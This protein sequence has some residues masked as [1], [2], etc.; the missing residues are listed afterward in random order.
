MGLKLPE[1]DIPPST[2]AARAARRE[3]RARDS[4]SRAPLAQPANRPDVIVPN[5]GW[6]GSFNSPTKTIVRLEEPPAHSNLARCARTKEREAGTW[7]RMAIRT[8]AQAEMLR[9]QTIDG[10]TA[11]H[12]Q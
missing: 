4:G 9:Q 10:G 2:V 11:P 3:G 7:I 6:S 1:G 5:E 8:D 12:Y